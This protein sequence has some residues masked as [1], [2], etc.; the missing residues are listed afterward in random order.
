M[1]E[2]VL[3]GEAPAAHRD[4]VAL[5]TALVLWTSG[6]QSDLAAGVQLAL[7]KMQEGRPWRRLVSLRDALEG[8]KEE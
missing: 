1:L 5:N 8:R 4:V 6:V 3:K 7:T 2:A